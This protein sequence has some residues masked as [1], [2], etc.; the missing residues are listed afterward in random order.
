MQLVISLSQ[1]LEHF[2]E[3][4]Q[5]LKQ[6]VGEEKSQFILNNSIFIVLTGN[7]DLFGYFDTPLRRLQYDIHSYTDLLVNLASS[8][9]Q[10]L[11]QYKFCVC[12]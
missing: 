1:Q 8:F 10:V 3:Y 2:K 7:N 4:I 11:F 6:L 12:L 5:K 9:L